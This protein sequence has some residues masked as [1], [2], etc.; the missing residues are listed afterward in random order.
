MAITSIKKKKKKVK[1]NTVKTALQFQNV[2][3]GGGC[4]ME[5]LDLQGRWDQLASTPLHS[6]DTA[7]YLF[8]WLCN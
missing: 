6:K 7:G 4:Q 3:V 2:S 1:K 8:G 5:M